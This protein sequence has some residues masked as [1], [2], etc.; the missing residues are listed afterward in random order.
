MVQRV[1]GTE[2]ESMTPLRKTIASSQK[3]KQDGVCVC[4]CVCVCGGL[5][6]AVNC[7]NHTT[8]LILALQ[9][10]QIGWWWHASCQ[11]AEAL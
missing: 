11:L 8:P 10:W 4:V 3:T 1:N 2:T 7:C 6:C 5:T 9:T